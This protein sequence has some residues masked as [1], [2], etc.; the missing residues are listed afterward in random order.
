M[1]GRKDENGLTPKQLNF[2]RAYVKTGNASEAYRQ[3][4]SAKNMKA[5]TVAKRAYDLMRDGQVSGMIASLKGDADK[6]AATDLGLTR[7]WVIAGLMRNAKI[8]AAVDNN[9][10][11]SPTFS[12]AAAN[13]A[14]VALG[15]VDTLSL[16]M[17][18]SKVE[19]SKTIDEMSD[20]ELDAYIA[21]RSKD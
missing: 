4:Y 13:A 10:E 1:A 6:A 14:L 11:P 9:G 17:E 20:E 15:K 16:F 5:E 12:P 3:S 7:E 8:F 18:R 2:C 21:E 19:L